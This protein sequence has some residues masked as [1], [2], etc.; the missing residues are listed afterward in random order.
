MTTPR[1][2]P[3]TPW[4]LHLDRDGTEDFL[5]IA[6]TEGHDLVR[7][8]FFWMPEN[9]D[10]VPTTLAAVWLMFHAP[11]LLEALK[12]LAEQAHRDCP[13]QARSTDFIEAL[14]RATRLIA[15]VTEC[16]R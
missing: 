15:G 14:D 4:K 13:A 12:I 9:D 2:N 11:E 16:P 10:P 6:S 7:S 1:P 3:G 5:T 8:E